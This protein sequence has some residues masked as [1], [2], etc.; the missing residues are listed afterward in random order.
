MAAALLG[1]PLARGREVVTELARGSLLDPAPSRGTYRFHDLVRAH[2]LERGADDAGW[3]AAYGRAAGS[4]VILTGCAQA[5]ACPDRLAYPRPGPSP[6]DT[7]PGL[8]EELRAD[9]EADPAGWIE[10]R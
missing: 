10:D 3:A 8:P 7:A 1:V 9:V 4:A 2:G 6:G 5:T